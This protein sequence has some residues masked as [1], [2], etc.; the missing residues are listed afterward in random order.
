[1]QRSVNF[2]KWEQK[3]WSAANPGRLDDG[4]REFEMWRSP[5]LFDQPS[6]LEKIAPRDGTQQPF[7]YFAR[8]WD[9]DLI[10][11]AYCIKCKASPGN[12]IVSPNLHKQCHSCKK[13]FSSSFISC[14]FYSCI[15]PQK[16]AGFY[17]SF[18]SLLKAAYSATAIHHL[19]SSAQPNQN[20]RI[21]N[22][23]QG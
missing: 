5:G 14:S 15:Q 2:G 16:P 17:D 20:L 4:F 3:P 6:L 22:C 1:M 7:S 23:G 8:Q 13:D 10:D 11:R 21:Q 18:P 19:P 9:S 12:C